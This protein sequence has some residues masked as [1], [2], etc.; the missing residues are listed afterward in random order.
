MK[1]NDMNNGVDK[2]VNEEDGRNDHHNNNNNL[3]KKAMMNNEQI[4]RT[5]DIDNAKEMLRKISSESSSR[6][7]SLLNKDSSL[8]N[9]NANSGGGTSINGTRGTSKSSNTHFQYASTA[10]GVRMLSKDIS[11]TKVELDVENLMIVT[12]LNDVSLYFLTRE[13]V[14]WVLVHFP[15]VTVYV[16]SELKN[17]KKFAAGELCEDSKCRES[18]IKYWTKDFIREHDVFFDL[19]VTLGG[20]GTVL[21]VSSLFQRHVPPVMSFSLGSLGFLTNFKFEHFREDLP[22]IMHHKIKTNLRLR[23]ECTIYRRHR[24]E[25]DPNTGKKICVVEK[26]STHHILNEVTIDRGPSPFLSML[27]LYGDGSL[28]TV[29]QADGLIAATPTGSTAYSLSAGGSLVCPTV[30]AIALTPICPHALSFRPIIL[31]ESINLKVKVSMKSRAPAWAAFDG[32]DRIEL[33]KGDFIT[34]CASPYAFP[35]VE[36]S[37]DEFINSIS[38]QLNWNV[39]EQQKSFTHILSQKNQEKYAHEANKVRNQAE[40]LEVIRD[41]YSL[42]ADAIKENNN[43]SDDESDDESEN[44]EACKLKPSSVPKPSQARFSV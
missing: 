9:G 35:T 26:L 12:K 15:R 42:E 40:P 19:V 14:E 17:S 32:K 39:R 4:D 37:P 28:M 33:Q 1:E 27:E 8:V 5:Q 6:R 7:S 24:P 25:V 44:C 10:Y 29:A 36:A 13:L 23:L 31:P 43:G 22:R 3:M 16:D 18:R 34:I 20:D 30:N 41:K 2:W 21:F 38:R 11:N